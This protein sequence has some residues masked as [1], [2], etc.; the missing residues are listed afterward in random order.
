MRRT[1]RTMA[2]VGWLVALGTGLWACGDSAFYD[3]QPEEGVATG[4]SGGDSLGSGVSV[5]RRIPADGP[6]VDFGERSRSRDSEGE[7][8]R[9][10]PEAVSD[11][12]AAFESEAVEAIRSAEELPGSVFETPVEP[13]LNEDGRLVVE[14][15]LQEPVPHSAYI[16]VH[17]GGVLYIPLDELEPGVTEIM[18]APKESP[19]RVVERM[20][21]ALVEAGYGERRA[22]RLVERNRKQMFERHGSRVGYVAPQDWVRGD[23]R[24]PLGGVGAPPPPWR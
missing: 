10:F 4:G 9:S 18:P 23:F 2:V 13:R 11:S 17:S 3:E 20:R 21:N 12:Y 8:P 6:R 15:L 5:A 16:H 22:E 1:V 7:M 24:T 19:G 14:N